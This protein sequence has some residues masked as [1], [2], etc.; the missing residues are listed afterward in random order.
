MS[1][2]YRYRNRAES[3]DRPT[4]PAATEEEESNK[5][6]DGLA[7]NLVGD[8]VARAARRASRETTPRVSFEAT[9]AVGDESLDA[10]CQTNGGQVTLATSD[11]LRE[12]MRSLSDQVQDIRD[13]LLKDKEHDNVGFVATVLVNGRK[14]HS[15]SLASLTSLQRAIIKASI[16]N[17]AGTVKIVVD[18]Y[19][20]RRREFCRSPSP[21]PHSERSFTD[22]GSPFVTSGHAWH[23]RIV[24]ARGHVDVLSSRRRRRRRSAHD[25]ERIAHAR[26]AKRRSRSLEHYEQLPEVVAARACCGHDVFTLY[27]PYALQNGDSTF[28]LVRSPT[29]E[30]I[31]RYKH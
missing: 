22:G 7:V 24:S 5:A 14:V 4:D 18:D 30:I 8:H 12:T 20:M 13:M 21:R 29:S 19:R 6:R 11:S 23:D 26:D 3:A 9:D 1:Y 17:V 10:A 2:P 31:P 27:P 25:V 15:D 28:R 16:S